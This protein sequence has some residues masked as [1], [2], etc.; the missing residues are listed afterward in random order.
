MRTLLTILSLLCASLVAWGAQ[1]Y[2]PTEVEGKQLSAKLG[3]SNA[4]AM[5]GEHVTLT[6][7]VDLYPGMHVYAP[8]VEDYIPIDWKME[9]SPGVAVRP[10]VFPHAEKLYLK[11]IDE[12]VPAYRN[13]FR[14]TRDIAI[15][16]KRDPS[17][18]LT[19]SGTLRY[20]ACDDRVCYI[21]Q[22]L[23]LAWTFPY[24]PR[25]K[26]RKPSAP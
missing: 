15:G 8:G 10:A 11:A 22:Q 16:G 26:P 2:V 18:K 23:H 3:A 19:V 1:S 9:E 24:Q 7:D 25:S 6:L 17:G 4:T 13:H 21:P 5:P 12:T 20:Q 14:L